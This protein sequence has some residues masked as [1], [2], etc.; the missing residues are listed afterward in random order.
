MALPE[1]ILFIDENYIKRYTY[2]NGSVDP[3]LMYPSIYIAQDEHVQQILGTDLFN[4]VKDLISTGDIS[5]P[6]N[7]NY[8]TLL[9]D[10]LRKATC[11]WS[12]YEMLPHLYIKTDN[13]SLV[14]RTS[15]STTSISMD[16]FTNYRNEAKQKALYYSKILVNYICKNQQFFP[17]YMTNTEGQFWSNPT[18]FPSNNY[19]FSSGRDSRRDYVNLDR[20]RLFIYGS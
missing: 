18:I 15:E 6:A 8:K 14:I 10:Y 19:A 7:V 9:D 12:M 13:G 4:K 5:D 3:L 2:V 16:D 11:W 17:E 20:I 1:E